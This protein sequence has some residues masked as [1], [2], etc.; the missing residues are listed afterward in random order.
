MNTKEVGKFLKDLRMEQNLTQ[1]QLGEKIGVTNKTISRWENGNYMPPIEN[2]QAL[3][4][5]YNI[6]INE[7]LSAKRLSNEELKEENF[8]NYIKAIDEK[9]K[10]KRMKRYIAIGIVLM[11]A[12][13]AFFLSENA[14]GILDFVSRLICMSITLFEVIVLTVY[15][16]FDYQY[17]K[18]FKILCWILFF[19]LCII[20]GVSS[21]FI[22]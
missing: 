2:L 13:I 14:D 12:V 22:W 18:K 21:K 8:E 19:A 20:T 15:E 6:S 16:W 9:L 5:L 17:S 7:I 11:V 10:T 3:S 1:E 4:E